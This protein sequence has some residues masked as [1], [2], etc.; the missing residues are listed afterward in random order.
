MNTI[1]DFQTYKEAA[2]VL[3]DR[4]SLKVA[5]NTYLERIDDALALRYH[6]THI[7]YYHP[8]HSITI[9]C[10]DWL[11]STTKQRLDEFTPFSFSGSC[12]SGFSRAPRPAYPGSMWGDYYG[13]HEPDNAGQNWELHVAG[14][15][16]YYEDGMRMIRSPEGW[17]VR[18]PR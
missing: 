2:E 8:D 3:K 18:Y 1:H 4:D 17:K 10:D 12:Y 5:H 11:T 14:E 13:G 15:P 7:I 9:D 16:Y 6:N